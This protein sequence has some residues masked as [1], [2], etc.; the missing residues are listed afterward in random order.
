MAAHE[1]MARWIAAFAAVL[2]ALFAAYAGS[3]LDDAARDATRTRMH[4]DARLAASALKR[5][6]AWDDPVILEAVAAEIA[7]AGA[8]VLRLYSPDGTLLLDSDRRRVSPGPSAAPEA[9]A[10]VL[11]RGW[12]STVQPDPIGGGRELNVAVAVV[13]G[14][15]TLGVLRLLGPYP[16][17]TAHASALRWFAVGLWILAAA[18]AVLLA[19]SAA[20]VSDEPIRHIS[21]VAHRLCDGDLSARIEPLPEGDLRQLAVDVNAAFDGI[22]RQVET[23]R[24]ESRY[25]EAVLEQMSDAVVVVNEHA[26]IRF[27]NRAFSKL[28]NVVAADV[29]NRHVETIGLGYDTA[30]L[31]VRALEQRTVQRDRVL[32]RSGSDTRT[33]VGVAAA[34]HSADG[35]VTGAVGLYHDITDLQ[36]ADQIRR[37]FV[38]N[39]SH[40]LRTPAAGIKALAEALQAG[41]INDPVKGPRF[42]ERIVATSERLANI[43]DDLLTLTRV[44]RGEELLHPERVSVAEAFSEAILQVQLLASDRGVTLE[45]ECAPDD[46]VF[47]DARSVQTVLVNL[48]DNA[49]KYT[50][51]GGQVRL[52]G[53]SVPGGYEMSVSDT[54]VGIPEQDLSRIFERFYRVDKARDRATGGTGLGLAIVK[55]IVEAHGGRVTVQSRLDE[56]STFRIYLPTAR[57]GQG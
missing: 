5:A 14:G 44:E 30:A 49:V 20:G 41:A 51:P 52:A 26:R 8:V 16:A 27:V 43:L 25:Y 10:R 37:D 36:R 4:R 28:M 50:P 24:N 38:S 18:G 34:L 9:Q 35:A 6:R 54:G 56:G 23:F 57:M 7:H 33:I 53:I 12:E 11:T 3:L 13:D 47:A 1:R 22:V 19:A 2:L 40:E 15:E 39:A 42:V 46:A 29:G 31:L 45:R 48:L 21:S 17:R 55:H 32:L